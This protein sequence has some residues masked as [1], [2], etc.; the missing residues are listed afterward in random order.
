[1]PIIYTRC[2]YVHI[3]Q[4]IGQEENKH[5]SPPDL[6]VLLYSEVGELLMSQSVM[7][8]ME[9]GTPIPVRQEYLYVFFGSRPL[10]VEVRF[11]HPNG[12]T[13]EH[14][15]HFFTSTLASSATDPTAGRD[16]SSN[17]TTLN[18]KTAGPQ[19]VLIGCAK[20]LCIE[21]WYHHMF[22]SA[23]NF[24]TLILFLSIYP[25]FL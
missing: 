6:D 22:Y 17:P 1:M 15:K 14:L 3:Y 11:Y 16:A 23:A 19:N 10:T 24:S 20:H 8:G 25:H 13:G 12:P 4:H 9:R 5:T 18:M 21:D 7:A 2:S